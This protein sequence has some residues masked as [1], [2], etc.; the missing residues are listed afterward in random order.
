MNQAQALRAIRNTLRLELLADDIAKPVRA[1][2]REIFREVG[3]MVLALDEDPTLGN[4]PNALFKGAR[5][6][7]LEAQILAML[8]PA[9]DALYDS[10][11][12]MMAAEIPRQIEDAEKMLLDGGITP[13][14]RAS[15]TSPGAGEVVNAP[16]VGLGLAGGDI[17]VGPSI[18]RTQL[19]QFRRMAEDVEVL[20]KP[21]NRLFASALPQPAPEPV[22]ALSAGTRTWNWAVLS[23]APRWGSS[24]RWFSGDFSSGRRTRRLPGGWVGRVRPDPLGRPRPS[25]GRRR[26]R[27]RPMLTRSSTK[28]TPTSSRV[29]NLTRRWIIA[30]ALHVLL[31]MEG[32]QLR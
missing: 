15:I 29:M 23:S 7:T 10:L 24:T 28:K 25:P 22:D 31:M 8:Q 32:R 4:S 26:C 5:F 9:N 2:L 20:G 12:E 13:Y 16:G 21:L 3:A 27:R 18:T 19:E 6:R 14:Q 11:V 30:S 17:T 1:R